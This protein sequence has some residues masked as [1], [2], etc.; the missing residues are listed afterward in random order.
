MTIANEVQEKTGWLHGVLPGKTHQQCSQSLGCAGLVFI[1]GMLLTGVS[2]VAEQAI[3]R[4][5]R[6]L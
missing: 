2:F 1:G 4:A 3:I 6:K 5:L